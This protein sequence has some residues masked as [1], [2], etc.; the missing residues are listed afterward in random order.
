MEKQIIYI[1]T[2][3]SYSD[4]GIN[5]VF[6]TKELAQKYI[7]AFEKQSFEGFDI[8]E[9]ELNPFATDLSKGRKPFNILMDIDGNV[10]KIESKP[11]YFFFNERI[12][13]INAHQAYWNNEKDLLQI[14]IFAND[15]THAVKIAN[16][17]R[18]QIIALNR[19]KDKE[20]SNLLF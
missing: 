15:E 16:E 8:E 18:T 9:W 10:E 19:W 5:A 13:Y 6:S 2:S 3:G 7:D 12:S 11:S 14:A 4:Y 17:K 1:V 20:L